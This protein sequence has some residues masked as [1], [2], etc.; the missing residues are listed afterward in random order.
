VHD[1]T[2]T[3]R[4]FAELEDLHCGGCGD[5]V[6]DGTDGFRHGDG[7]ALCTGDVVEVTA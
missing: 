5:D 6:A 3:D 2:N 4:R 1:Q 7:S